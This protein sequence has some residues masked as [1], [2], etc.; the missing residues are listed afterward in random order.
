M[1]I[2]AKV[3]FSFL[4]HVS[5]ITCVLTYLIRQTD[6]QLDRQTD[7][8]TDQICWIDWIDQ[9]DKID[10][11]DRQIQLNGINETDYIDQIDQIDRTDRQTDRQ[12]D[13]QGLQMVTVY[14][15]Q[16][17]FYTFHCWFNPILDPFSSQFTIYLNAVHV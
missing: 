9:I 3:C 17:H 4:H 2:F 12:I 16:F 14:P 7:R 1:C 5:F 11:I 13:R 8:Y 6:G 10:Q 15:M